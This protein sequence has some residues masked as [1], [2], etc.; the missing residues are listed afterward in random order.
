MMQ[1]SRAW[2]TTRTHGSCGAKERRQDYAY[3]VDKEELCDEV[4]DAHGGGRSSSRGGS[5]DARALG[6]WAAAAF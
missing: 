2:S 4:R 5:S 6:R 1:R 3:D